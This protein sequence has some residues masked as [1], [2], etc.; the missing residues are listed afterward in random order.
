MIVIISLINCYCIYFLKDQGRSISNPIS[1]FI[2]TFDQCLLNVCPVPALSS[3]LG[4]QE[5]SLHRGA[6]SLVKEEAFMKKSPKK[7]G[8]RCW[9]LTPSPQCSPLRYTQEHPKILHLRASSGQCLGQAGR[10]RELTSLGAA[11]NPWSMRIRRKSPASSP[12]QV[13][14]W[15][16]FYSFSRKPCSLMHLHSLPS[17]S[18]IPPPLRDHCFLGSPSK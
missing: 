12:C 2:H 6:Q 5:W 13:G 14:D 8:R 17:L 11:L 3:V 1:T 16:H 7:T 18:R 9:S 10:A 4:V 15:G